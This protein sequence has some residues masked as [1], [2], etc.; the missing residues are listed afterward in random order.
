MINKHAMQRKLKG[1]K[2]GSLKEHA[3]HD[4]Q[5]GPY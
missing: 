1:E 5:Y 3:T 4:N 2:G